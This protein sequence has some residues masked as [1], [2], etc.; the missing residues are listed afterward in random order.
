MAD[1]QNKTPS[2]ALAATSGAAPAT[3]NKP[4]SG[5]TGHILPTFWHRTTALDTKAPLHIPPVIEQPP[6]P[7]Q[8]ASV[9]RV[10]TGLTRWWYRALHR[11]PEP[12][13]LLLLLCGVLSLGTYLYGTLRFPLAVYLQPHYQDIGQLTRL[14]GGNYSPVAGEW[15]L[16]AIA[17]LFG[18]WGLA[19]WVAG[20]AEARARAG[21]WR[22]NTL[23]LLPLFGL[24]VAALAVLLFMYP[25]TAVDVIDYASQIRVLTIHHANPLTIPAGDFP[26]DLFVPYN[27]YYFIPASYGPLWA[28][29]SALASLPAGDH[30]LRAVLMQKLLSIVACLGCMAL[31][32]LLSKR[33]C[34]ERRWQAFVFFAWNPLV[35][36]EVGANGHNDVLM[37]FFLLAGLYALLAQRWYWQALALPLL[38]AS[39]F[40]KW[41]TILLLP[42]AIIYLLRG[43]RLRRWGLPALGLGTALT[44]A[45]A[46]P[47]VLPF[48]DAKHTLGVLLQS[49]AF[50]ASPLALLHA[51]LFPI[52]GDQPHS[53][54]GAGT[55]TIIT[56]LGG[57]GVL[58]VIELVILVRLAFPGPKAR[59]DPWKQLTHPQ[60]LMA[61][62]MDA[63]FWYCIFGTLAFHPWYLLVLIPLAALDPR[64]L[65]RTRGAMFAFGAPL[66]YLVYIF[67]WIIYWWNLPVFT[68]DLVACL[69]VFGLALFTRALEGVQ[70]RQH[71]YALLSRAQFPPPPP[72]ADESRRRRS[73]WLT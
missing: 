72:D 59:L 18:A 52:Y 20:R 37:A 47:L 11:R 39:V 1:D 23:L 4:R 46:I 38:M 55:A 12:L 17:V 13:T 15:L 2:G 26:N 54:N 30:I 44:V 35:L 62:C 58:A 61:A 60:R 24:P 36:F 10:S 27:P 65:A 14:P 34:P 28:V 25:V 51:L 16:I 41:T 66:S 5:L 70:T 33:L 45:Y 63:T 56:Q 64:P 7:E 21:W 50:T 8:P 3:Q 29:L 48:L 67:L 31:V 49:H 19:C 71:L 40:V 68:V 53:A 42:L 9:Q 69:S 22:P 32:W 6:A 73:W 43:G 57:A